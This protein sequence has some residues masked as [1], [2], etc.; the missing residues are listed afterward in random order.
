MEDNSPPVYALFE[1]FS[2]IELHTN[3]LACPSPHHRDDDDENGLDLAYNKAGNSATAEHGQHIVPDSLPSAL[4]CC[5]STSLRYK[6]DA[7]LSIT[8][9][10]L[11]LLC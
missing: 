3:F 8:V 2:Y 6:F 7:Y 9:M 11:P 4:I 1:F 10:C 5:A